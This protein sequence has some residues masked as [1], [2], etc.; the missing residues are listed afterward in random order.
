MS[1]RGWWIDDDGF[2]RDPSNVHAY[3]PG[4]TA[5]LLDAL[6]AQRDALAE[7]LRSIMLAL[8]H[9]NKAPHLVDKAR[10]ALALLKDGAQ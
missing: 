9:A 7:A 6:T 10:S 2:V 8:D 1:G 4:Q 5:D 3:N